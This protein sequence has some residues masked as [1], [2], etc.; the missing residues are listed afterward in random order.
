MNRS[1]RAALSS[2]TALTLVTAGAGCGDWQSDPDGF[3]EQD[4]AHLQQLVLT[5]EPADPGNTFATSSAARRLGQKLFFDLGMATRTADGKAVSCASCHSPKT[6]FSDPNRTSVSRG[7]GL[8]ARNSPSLVNVGFYQWWGWGGGADSIWGQVVHAFESKATMGGT[9]AI[10]H[11]RVLTKYEA[12]FNEAF[13]ATTGKPLS[14]LT[15]AEAYPFMLKAWGAY[16]A[17]LESKRAPFD[18][19]ASGEDPS[20]LNP[21]QKRGLKLFIG[22]A[23]CIQCHSGPSFSDNKFHSVGVG[24]VGDGV[25]A[26]DYGRWDS[27]TSLS[28]LVDAGY[29]Q[30]DATRQESDRGQF[31]TKSLRQVAMTGPYFHAGQ[32]DTLKDVVW[33]YNQGGDHAGAGTVSTFLVPLGLSEEEQADLVVFLGALTGEPV[34]RELTWDLACDA[35][36]VVSTWP[37]ASLDGGLGLPDG[38]TIRAGS[39][40]YLEERALA[41]GGTSVWV[42]EPHPREFP[43]L[44]RDSGCAP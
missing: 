38:G 34:A 4:W 6:W 2:V 7:V 25:P 20:A 18:L 44:T 13:F 14:Q 10:V 5:N 26:D 31:R 1:A 3:T 9:A 36:R 27:L 39:G 35:Q 8:T 43:D 19:F 33:F 29:S 16:I 23:G 11:A 22:K 28:K 24:Q 30:K 21:Q 17:S 40:G 37:G 41:D 15:P 32:L 12:D 42:F